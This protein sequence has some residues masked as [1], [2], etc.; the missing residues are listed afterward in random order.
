M[1]RP[2]T[3]RHIQ[4]VVRL[5][6]EE[7]EIINE[8]AQKCGLSPAQY[9]RSCGLSKT[10]KARGDASRLDPDIQKEVWKSVSGFGRNLNQVA[11][12]FNRERIKGTE[13]VKFD[14]EE[15]RG[16]VKHLTGLVLKL[17]RDEM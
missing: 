15:L 9:L 4:R 14:V 11:L 8:K 12:F 13:S 17:L 16:E 6:T 5:T 3:N 7:S 10:L 2:K 1:S